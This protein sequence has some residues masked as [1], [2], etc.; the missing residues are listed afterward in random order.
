MLHTF[1]KPKAEKAKGKHNRA[2]IALLCHKGP[3]AAVKEFTFSSN[4][5]S[6]FMEKKKNLSIWL[7]HAEF[8]RVSLLFHN[9]LCKQKNARSAVWQ[10]GE[11]P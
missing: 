7:Y 1:T 2:K 10:V 5:Y 9:L 6:C 3:S 8:S 4:V 11:K